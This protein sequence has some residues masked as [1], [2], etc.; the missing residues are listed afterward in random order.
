MLPSNT[1][2]E[3]LGDR[4][5]AETGNVR[6][7]KIARNVLVVSTENLLNGAAENIIETEQHVQSEVLFDTR[8]RDLLCSDEQ[9]VGRQY[10]IASPS[11]C[12]NDF[13]MTATMS[14]PARNH[15]RPRLSR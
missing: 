11:R 9:S 10:K 2:A 15:K 8:E 13:E 12:D 1:E 6:S 7:E 3:Q 4:S 14:T 5:V